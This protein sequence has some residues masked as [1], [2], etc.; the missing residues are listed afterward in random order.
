MRNTGLSV[1]GYGQHGEA[2]SLGGSCAEPCLGMTSPSDA[3]AYGTVTLREAERLP[4][5]VASPWYIPPHSAVMWA[6]PAP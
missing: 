5:M 6:Q 1:I 2:G 4:A 3:S